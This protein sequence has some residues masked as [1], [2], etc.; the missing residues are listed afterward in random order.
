M[1]EEDIELLDQRIVEKLAPYE[2]EVVRL[3]QISGVD[4]DNRAL[5]RLSIFRSDRHCYPSGYYVEWHMPQR[6]APM[7]FDEVSFLAQLA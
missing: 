4:G 2:S 6:L 1:I 7:L 3:K 5:C